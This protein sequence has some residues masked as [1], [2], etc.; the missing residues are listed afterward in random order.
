MLRHDSKGGGLYYTYHYPVW[1]GMSPSQDLVFQGG[2]II[3]DEALG[4]LLRQSVTSQEL[5]IPILNERVSPL[6]ILSLALQHIPYSGPHLGL[7]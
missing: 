4:N 5:F 6:K 1:Y 3:L 7:H 2:H